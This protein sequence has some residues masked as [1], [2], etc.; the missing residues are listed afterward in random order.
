[1]TPPTQ[2]RVNHIENS[3]KEGDG[4][5]GVVGVEWISRVR[6]F[7]SIVLVQWQSETLRVVPKTG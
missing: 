6:A 7:Y 3:A 5:D 1:M 2:E 4:G